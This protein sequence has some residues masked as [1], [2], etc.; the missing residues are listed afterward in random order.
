MTEAMQ[1]AILVAV[2]LAI[3]HY[4]QNGARL[5]VGVS[6]VSGA[7]M[8][9]CGTWA[10]AVVLGKV[11]ASPES[12][13]ASLIIAIPILVCRGNMAKIVDQLTPARRGR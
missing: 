13:F 9:L 4:K 8:G 2:V 11:S 5:R 12:L 1:V 10:L 3:G 6:A 7:V